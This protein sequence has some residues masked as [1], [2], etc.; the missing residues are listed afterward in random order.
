M[1]GMKEP[2]EE[3]NPNGENAPGLSGTKPNSNNL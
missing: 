3:F 2:N 1:G